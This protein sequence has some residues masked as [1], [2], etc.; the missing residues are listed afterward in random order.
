MLRKMK[1]LSLCAL[2]AVVTLHFAAPVSEAK[3]TVTTVRERTHRCHCKA[4]CRVN[5]KLQSST[6]VHVNGFS[7]H[8]HR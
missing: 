1:F 2:V 6:F 4:T 5:G 8:W 7:S 3:L